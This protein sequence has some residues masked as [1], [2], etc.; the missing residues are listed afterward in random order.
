MA[1]AA[2]AAVAAGVADAIAGRLDA[3]TRVAAANPANPA[4]PTEAA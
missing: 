2:P 3:P 1:A 4:A